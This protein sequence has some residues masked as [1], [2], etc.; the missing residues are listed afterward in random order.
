MPPD[1]YPIFEDRVNEI[2]AERTRKENEAFR[3]KAEEAR[4]KAEEARQNAEEARQKAEEARQKAEEAR[5][6]AEAL[7]QADEEARQHAKE[8]AWRHRLQDEAVWRVSAGDTAWM[9]SNATISNRLIL[10][11]QLDGPIYEF[12]QRFW[13]GIAQID[14]RID[15]WLG[16]PGRLR[17]VS[18]QDKY[19]SNPVTVRLLYETLLGLRRKIGQLRV[20]LRVSTDKKF[21]DKTTGRFLMDDWVSASPRDDVLNA[22]LTSTGFLAAAVDHNASHQRTLEIRGEDETRLLLWLDWGFGYWTTKRRHQFDFGE[23][24]TN[25]AA[26]LRSYNPWICAN[27]IYASGKYT[28]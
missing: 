13:R 24:T 5:Q 2:N 1:G 25:Q 22:L 28:F 23:S 11:V 12:G 3:Q 16:N 6:R 7:R 15:R 21:S 14:P 4:Q 26:K 20:P 19:L 27:P 17:E 10:H 9:V 18:Y 8:E